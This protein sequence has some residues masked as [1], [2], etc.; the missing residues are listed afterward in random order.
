MRKISWKEGQHGVAAGWGTIKGLQTPRGGDAS[1]R[2][3]DF[4][5]GDMFRGDAQSIVD[6]THPQQ[7]EVWELPGK[8]AGQ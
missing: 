2:R 5:C 3:L 7:L 8:V 6:D 1:H 4:R